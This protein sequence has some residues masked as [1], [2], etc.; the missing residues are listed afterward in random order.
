MIELCIQDSGDMSVG[1]FPQSWDI[2]TPFHD[3]SEIDAMLLF[4]DKLV[5]I[6]RDFSEGRVSFNYLMNNEIVNIYELQNQN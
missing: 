2:E 5:E 6:Y 4:A 1:L 3:L